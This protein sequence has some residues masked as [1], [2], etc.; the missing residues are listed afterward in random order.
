MEI[1]ATL[2]E[3]RRLMRQRRRELAVLEAA[4]WLRASWE[5]VDCSRVGQRHRSRRKVDQVE[6]AK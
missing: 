4:L 6:V 1:P 3:L 5:S 2:P